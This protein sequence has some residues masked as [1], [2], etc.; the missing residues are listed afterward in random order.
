MR[1][2]PLSVMLFAGLTNA[3]LMAQFGAETQFV[4]QGPR[5]ICPVDL[6]A[7]GDQ[8]LVIGT[9][10]GTSIMTN[11][12]GL[13]LWSNPQPVAMDLVVASAVDVTGDGLPD[14]IGGRDF[15]MGLVWSAGTGA[16][17][18]T[19]QQ[20]VQANMAVAGISGA[21]LDGDGDND[22]LVRTEGGQAMWFRNTDGQGSFGPAI[23]LPAM[24]A[25]ALRTA[26]MNGDAVTDVVWASAWTGEVHCVYGTGGGAFGPDQV[27]AADGHGDAGD[28]DGDGHPDVLS[29]NAL[30]NG[31]K[32]RR[33]TTGNGV[34]A[35][36]Q[37]FAS[38]FDVPSEVN[39]VDLDLDGDLD[40]LTTFGAQGEIA[41]HEN[42]DGQGAFGPRQLIGVNVQD[43]ASV[44][45]ADVDGDGDAEVFAVS[46]SQNRVVAYENLAF[47]T[48]RIIGR[49]FNDIDADGLFNGADH[50]LG[51]F[52][53]EVAGLGSV[54][55]NHSGMYWYD[56]PTGTFNVSVAQ[57]PHWTPTTPSQRSA[58][59]MGANTG[60]HTDFG[61]MA[62]GTHAAIVPSV[63]N[64]LMR[65]NEQ[66]WYWLNVRNE[67]NTPCDIR[68]ALDLDSLLGFVYADKQPVT[69]GGVQTWSF[70]NVQPAQQRS[71]AVV[72]QLPDFTHMGELMHSTLTATAE[73]NGSVLA[74]SVAAHD[75]EL[76]CSYDPN[77][78][79]VMPVGDGEEHWTPMGT[80][81]TYTVR[82][83]NTGN[84]YAED[85][86]IVD[87]LD[88][89]L[90][91]SSLRVLNASHV[92]RTTVSSTGEVRF[93]F[94][95]IMLPDSATDPLGSQ[96][97][98][99]F[100]I[101]HA[102]GLP[103]ATEVQNVAG[104]YFDL[105]P[106][107][108]TN[109]VYNTLTYATSV[110]P[111]P[112]VGEG[113][114]LVYPNP[115]RDM[116][117]VVLGAEIPGTVELTLIDVTGRQVRGWRAVGGTRTDVPR[118]DLPAG[119]YFL[120][121]TAPGLERTARLVFE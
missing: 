55:T 82:F 50:G 5:T 77:D 70:T 108:I 22:L 83:Q 16:S 120:R 105:N 46:P 119:L 25:T 59:L 72:V 54:Y 11:T 104:I 93:R 19:A 21:D 47:A 35:A 88:A 90:V 10:E 73:H 80:R 3:P 13:G 41:F 12:D 91:P 65:C 92:V 110:E 24:A 64:G 39:L 60:T 40:L 33:N 69:V 62:N 71:I 28:L 4:Y 114:L 8:D 57:H 56:V 66:T 68:L 89:S 85:V 15:G 44:V 117:A 30:P 7:D 116:A 67:G 26:D 103:E 101:E 118:G 31:M 99:R 36:P 38:A 76:T 97:H 74:T 111:V 32:W 98:V 63:T 2:P 81:L 51:G 95:D 102:A 75:P 34:L 17:F 43:V 84:S 27:L 14:L 45:A 42:I 107:I 100:S 23:S 106:P 9:R 20:T 49:V 79:Q 58:S 61:L 113:G 37:S 78:K 87:Q 86:E 109:T 29:A 52:R 6:D 115:A 121:A 1:I 53:V 112:A 18:S 94:E 96:G 48:G